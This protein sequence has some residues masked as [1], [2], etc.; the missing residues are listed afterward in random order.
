VRLGAGDKPIRFGAVSKRTSSWFGAPS[1]P[2]CTPAIGY[3][4]PTIQVDMPAGDSVRFTTRE[5]GSCA[6]GRRR[7]C[8]CGGRTIRGAPEDRFVH[9]GGGADQIANEAGIQPQPLTTALQ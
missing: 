7:R 4:M 9:F 6:T 8:R 5:P 3:L 1:R 2:P